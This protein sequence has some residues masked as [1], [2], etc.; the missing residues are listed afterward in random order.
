MLQHV[1]ERWRKWSSTPA[2][3]AAPVVPSGTFNS[4]ARLH[5]RTRGRSRF[6]NA[7]APSSSASS[8]VMRNST[9]SARWIAR[10]KASVEGR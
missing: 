2:T 4:I 1:R 6:V 8:A 7:I 9:W 3:T 10:T 5:G